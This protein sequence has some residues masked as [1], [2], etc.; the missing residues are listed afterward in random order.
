M[1][2]SVVVAIALLAASAAH[3]EPD[4]AYSF[5][6]FPPKTI[7]A[8]G[9]SEMDAKVIGS[10]AMAIQII[11]GYADFYVITGEPY[12]GS[13]GTRYLV[14]EQAFSSTGLGLLSY[15]DYG[16]WLLLFDKDTSNYHM[17]E[18]DVNNDLGAGAYWIYPKTGSP[19][20]AG[21][22]LRSFRFAEVPAGAGAK[23]LGGSDE[24]ERLAQLPEA[25]PL[26]SKQAIQQVGEMSEV[27]EAYRATRQAQ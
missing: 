8:D 7:H 12:V 4:K 11:T 1:I 16:K 21:N 23:S 17:Y 14:V 25:G 3:A 26:L 9:F 27:L 22:W 10:W 5:S 2:R 19:T 6:Q 13:N 15:T 18:Y 24:H 20:G